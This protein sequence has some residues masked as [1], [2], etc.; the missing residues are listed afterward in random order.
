VGAIGLVAFLLLLVSVVAGWPSGIPWALGLLGGEYATALALRSDGMVDAAAPLYGAGLLVL[1][2]LAYWSADLRGLGRE[3]TQVVLRRLAGLAVLAFL[4]VLLGAF[5][6]V[7]TA[8][9]LGGGLLWDAVGVAAA[10]ATLAIVA[11]LAYR[12]ASS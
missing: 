3:E 10:A 9:P 5:I 12:S 1:A 2:E 6:V 7:V 8:A 4:S 11:R